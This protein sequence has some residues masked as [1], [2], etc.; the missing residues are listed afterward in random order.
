MSTSRYIFDTDIVI[1]FLYVLMLVG[2]SA[3]AYKTALV[4]AMGIY[5]LAFIQ[6]MFK[7]GRP[8][9]DAA[10]ISS[11][12]HCY[13]GFAGP[14]QGAFLMTFFWPYVIVMFL[15]KYY[16]HPHRVLNWVLL[17]LLVILWVD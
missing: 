10:N 3:L 15:F 14:S 6:M 11:N 8:F 4:T 17:A 7:S 9:W 1:L 12:G 13:F 2:D 16:K 5:I